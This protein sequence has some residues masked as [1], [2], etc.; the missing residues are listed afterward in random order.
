MKNIKESELY[1]PI[2][3]YFISNGYCV[4]G[5]V[6]NIDIVISKENE[7]NN[8]D[9]IAIELKTS[10][11]L[12]LLQQAVERQKIFDSVYVAIPMVKRTYKNKRFKEIVHILKRLEIGL[13]TV[14]FLKSGNVVAIEH[15]PLEFKK[16]KNNK[17]KRAIIKEISSRTGII[18]NIG[19]TTK[20]KKVTAYREKSLY[21]LCLLEK[22]GESTPKFLRGLGGDV[23]TTNI[24][25]ANFYKWFIRVNNGLYTISNIGR[26]A[27]VEYNEIVN[28][29]NL[30]IN[31]IGRDDND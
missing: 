12:K 16:R 10:F 24:L 22:Y 29:F 9:Y 17:K 21:L 2:K 30:K 23:K 20:I 18:D 11:N 31:E 26:E 19:G 4:N 28:F 1:M 25:Y 14:N 13:I 8:M 3:N 15:N 27:L 5:E 7:D 6:D